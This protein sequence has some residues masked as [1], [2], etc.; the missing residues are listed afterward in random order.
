MN[1]TKF[2]K[3]GIVSLILI[4]VGLVLLLTAGF[5]KSFDFTG[6][7]IISINIAEQEFDEAKLNVDKV[8]VK[9]NLRA[10]FYGVG[11]NDMGQCLIIKY[12]IFNDINSTNE[13]VYEDLF[14]SFEYDSNDILESKY[15][16]MQTNTLPAY[17][18]EVFIKAILASLIALVGIA[19]YVI[20]RYNLTTGFVLI[21]TS[22][23]DLATMFS[24]TLITRIPIS[25]FIDLAI[26][27]IV[28]VS[29][30]I[31]FLMLNRINNNAKL[32]ENATLSNRQLADMT[33][34]EN[35]KR[36][37]YFGITFV[38]TLLLLS[39]WIDSIASFALL[40][41]VL[42][43]I[44]CIFSSYFITPTLWSLSFFRKIKK[45]KSATA[46]KVKFKNKIVDAIEVNSNLEN[47][48]LNDNM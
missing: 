9:N 24:L 45:Y 35:S 10:S 8:L 40:S 12:Q 23:L 13:Q 4:A 47:D 18:S 30:F 38:A 34:K 25:H 2:L 6:G 21:A 19:I 27:G 15:I 17:G 1:L 28:G 5:N 43:I 11:E 22:I 39:I 33:V 44:T 46:D 42:G 7:T 31:N 36:N 14:S 16:N 32:E 26:F 3:S 48:R 20:A 41:F 37:F 29:I